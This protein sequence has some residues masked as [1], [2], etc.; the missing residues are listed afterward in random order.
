MNSE[1]DVIVAYLTVNKY[2]SRI[3]T[4]RLVLIPNDYSLKSAILEIKWSK[5]KKQY[6]LKLKGSCEK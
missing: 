3:F 1:F 5:C 6:S 2:S 4:S